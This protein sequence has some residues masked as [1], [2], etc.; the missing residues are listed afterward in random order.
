M[1]AWALWLD[2]ATHDNGQFPQAIQP[3]HG[4]GAVIAYP[5]RLTALLTRLFQ[6]G[7]SDGVRRFLARSSS[8]HLFSPALRLLCF[9]VLFLLVD[10]TCCQA[11]FSV[12]RKTWQTYYDVTAQW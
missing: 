7:Q 4:A 6:R 1:V 2:T 10:Y 3:G 9:S 12:Q 8:S 11:F 5:Q